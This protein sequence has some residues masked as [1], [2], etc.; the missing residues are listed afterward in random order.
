M[1][2]RQSQ[3]QSQSYTNMAPIQRPAAAS[4]AM[5]VNPQMATKMKIAFQEYLLVPTSDGRILFYQVLD[6][7]RAECVMQ[8]Y[9]LNRNLFVRNES[10]HKN[11]ANYKKMASKI[12]QEK[13]AVQPVI[14][15]G[16]F[17]AGE[18]R[19]KS[20]RNISDKIPSNPAS[21]V[22]IC[23]CEVE[24]TKQTQPSLLG[25][26]V[27]LVQEGDVHVFELYSIPNTLSGEK[28]TSEIKVDH[29]HS[30]HSGNIGATSLAVQ[31]TLKRNTVVVNNTTL[32]NHQ[33]ELHIAVG[34][35]GGTVT[36][37]IIVER[38]HVF[39][40]KGFL[41]GSVQ[42]LAYIHAPN[43]DEITR[44]ESSPSP[45]GKDR[46]AYLLDEDLFLVMGTSL[47]VGNAI[48]SH[49]H[50]HSSEDII[51][52]CL[53]VVNTS[54]VE[55]EWN[56]KF[57]GTCSNKTD[58]TL[59]LLDL[60]I[61]PKN[62]VKGD[63]AIPISVSGQKKK[64]DCGLGCVKAVSSISKYISDFGRESLLHWLQISK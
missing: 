4:L 29:I 51:S 57:R 1:N 13:E 2:H 61:W 8:E 5:P 9:E 55:K 20:L 62:Q 42:A 19:N 40:W 49:S 11:I 21:I 38:R 53:D 44:K 12:Q 41:E 54:D 23:I 59:D 26:I 32:R 15:L 35:D 28:D 36:E 37:F 30:F 16:P 24:N 39:K 52:S 47:N 10:Y 33:P 46:M 7:Y 6:F 45:H 60:I 64:E 22:D 31:R 34:Y 27:V 63:E 43:Q 58:G 3:S 25:V 18:Y 14:S 17:N 48:N 50:S 56:S